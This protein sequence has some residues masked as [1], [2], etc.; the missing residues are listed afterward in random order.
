MLDFEVAGGREAAWQFIYATELM[1]LTSVMPRLRVHLATTTCGR[2][3]EQQRE[4]AGISKNL[5]RTAVGLED[6]ED[7]RADFE[8]G[9][10]VAHRAR[11]SDDGSTTTR[12]PTTI[13]CQATSSIIVAAM[14]APSS[15]SS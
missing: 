3:S 12:R 11:P 2:S 8:R 5:I 14:R 13:S 15:A 6:I 1:S 7:L 4:A 9:T 10:A